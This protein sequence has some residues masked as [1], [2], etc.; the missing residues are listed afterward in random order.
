[1]QSELIHKYCR[2]CTT[3]GL[4]SVSYR[5]N[6]WSPLTGY[7]FDVKRDIYT[8]SDCI[9]ALAQASHPRYGDVQSALSEANLSVFLPAVYAAISGTCLIDARREFGAI[10]RGYTV[11]K[12]LPP[13]ELIIKF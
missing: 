8:S 12:N 7:R 10:R 13:T 9:C 1:M 4:V 6:E 2:N 11:Q 5:M 3:E